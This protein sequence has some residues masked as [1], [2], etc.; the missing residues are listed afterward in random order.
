LPRIGK[1][2]KLG[3]REKK[4]KIKEGGWPRETEQKSNQV[5]H[6]KERVLPKKQDA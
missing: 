1:K 3:L 5:S 2:V 4:K 6:V